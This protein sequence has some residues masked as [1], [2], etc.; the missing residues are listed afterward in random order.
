MKVKKEKRTRMKNFM[1][2][3]YYNRIKGGIDGHY[4]HWKRKKEGV[5]VNQGEKKTKKKDWCL[6]IYQPNS[7][8]F[9]VKGRRWGKFIG[10]NHINYPLLPMN[11][12]IKRLLLLLLL[13]IA[14]LSCSFC[15]G[16]HSNFLLYFVEQ[17]IYWM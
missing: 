10:N 11:I 7:F 3:H 14:C 6:S 16:P 13:S 4:Y 15:V 12:I 17:L 9:I 2:L 5:K 8:D 1:F